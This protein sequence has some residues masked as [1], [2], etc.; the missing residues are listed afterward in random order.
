VVPSLVSPPCT[1]NIGTGTICSVLISN[2]TGSLNG[3]SST[4]NT[5]LQFTGPTTAVI[6]ASNSTLTGGALG[7]GNL[8]GTS[9][10]TLQVLSPTSNALTVELTITGGTA[11][12]AAAATGQKIRL[13][14]VTTDLGGGTSSITGTYGSN[15]FWPVG[16]C[17]AP[18]LPGVITPSGL[19]ATVKLTIQPDLFQRIRPTKDNGVITDLLDE[20]CEIADIFGMPFAGSIQGGLTPDCKDATITIRM[21]EGDVDLNC[22]VDV[23]DDQAMA[24]RYGSFFGNLLYNKFY[25]LEPN[26]APDFDI[27]IKDLQTVFGRNGSTCRTP[28]PDQPPGPQIPDP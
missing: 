17:G 11:S 10:G 20:N 8:T 4:S 9:T 1:L 25:D 12:C 18:L 24:F 28:I 16:L 14:L 19:A 26:I 3:I 2:F 15:T 7:G 23:A 5:H 21:L 22:N 27:D 13:N 6:V